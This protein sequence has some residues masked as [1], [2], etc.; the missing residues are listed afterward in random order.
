MTYKNS[1][2]S[3]ILAYN[4]FNDDGCEAAQNDVIEAQEEIKIAFE[5][6]PN[7]VVTPVIQTQ[8]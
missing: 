1:K 2:M 8:N 3:D 4:R 7:S 6:P 5:V